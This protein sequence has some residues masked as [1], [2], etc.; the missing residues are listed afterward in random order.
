MGGICDPM[1]N[2]RKEYNKKTSSGVKYY[3]IQSAKAEMQ[4][5]F[6]AIKAKN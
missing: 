1:N 2:I 6:K 5:R 4:S 3:H